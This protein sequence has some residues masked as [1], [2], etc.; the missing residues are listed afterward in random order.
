MSLTDI[1]NMHRMITEYSDVVN[2]EPGKLRTFPVTWGVPTWAA[3]TEEP[4]TAIFPA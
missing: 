2:N 4:R 1:L 3:F